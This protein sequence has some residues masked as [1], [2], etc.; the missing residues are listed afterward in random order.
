VEV[1]DVGD[2]GAVRRLGF[3][4]AGQW[5]SDVAASAGML[6]AADGTAGLFVASPESC[7]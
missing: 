1:F 6:F 3:Y 7:D 4:P 5:V 2:L